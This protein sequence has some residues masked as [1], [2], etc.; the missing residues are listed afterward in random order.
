MPQT[1]SAG[2]ETRLLV[3]TIVVSIVMLL[4]LARF[5]FPARPAPAAEPPPQPLE[6]LAARA[7]Y[8][9]LTSILRGVNDRVSVAVVAVSLVAEDADVGDRPA[10][11]AS[12]AAVRLPGNRAIALTRPG[13]RIDAVK[14]TA[15]TLVATDERR[16]VSLLSIAGLPGSPPDVLDSTEALE[17]PGYLAA[18][19]ATPAGLAVRPMYFG[20]IDRVADPAWTDP[21]LRFSALQQALPEGAA[22]FTLRGEFVGLGIPDGRDLIVVPSDSLQ[23]AAN[24]LAAS[25]SQSMADL[26]FEVQPLTSALRAATGATDGIMVSYVAA[27]GPA[28]RALR[29]G[30]VVVGIDDLVVHTPHDFRAA[31]VAAAV[32]QPVTIR[33][34]RDGVASTAQITPEPVRGAAAQA[35][36]RQL[37]LTLRND[38]GRGSDVVRVE[39]DS[40][41]GRAGLMEGDVITMLDGAPHPRPDDVLRAFGHLHSGQWLLVA[42]D[43]EGRHLMTAVGKP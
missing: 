29:A 4:V 6:R 5:R 17:A 22:I 24:S 20:R 37:G 32:G 16:G 12:T 10:T 23:R 3:V 31:A 42:V 2:K 26:G 33:F 43:R 34:V 11:R 39:P 13:Q 38:A 30:D 36:A 18:I 28:A 40:A 8:D 7:T 21:V 41:A 35:D 25:G 27:D 1:T 15:I 14:P 19:E 9:E